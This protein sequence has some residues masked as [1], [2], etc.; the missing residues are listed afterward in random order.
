MPSHGK[1]QLT[2]GAMRST[3]TTDVGICR[4]QLKFKSILV[5]TQKDNRPVLPFPPILNAKLDLPP[6]PPTPFLPQFL[7]NSFRLI[8]MQGAKSNDYENW[9]LGEGVGKSN[10][11]YEMEA[12]I[13][14]A[15]DIM[16]IKNKKASNPKATEKYRPGYFGIKANSIVCS[17]NPYSRFHK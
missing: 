8:H 17:S 2:S 11:A 12:K 5:Q 15:Q 16:N 3:T 7:C 6:P 13:K 9:V 14:K 10:F 4:S 1:E